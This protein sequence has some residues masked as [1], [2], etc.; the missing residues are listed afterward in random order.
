MKDNIFIKI[1][2]S[3]P[4][5]LITLYFLP[6]LGVILILLRLILSNNKRSNLFFILIV[7]LVL[8]IPKIISYLPFNL[9]NIPYLKQLINSEFYNIKIIKYSKFLITVSIIF[10][11]LNYLVNK[12][13]TNFTNHLKDKLVKYENNMEQQR[14]KAIKE[15]DM[16]IKERKEVAKNTSNIKCPYCGADNLIT[17][18]VGTCNYCRRKLE[19]LN[20][21]D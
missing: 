17:G 3:I 13:F 4:A 1:L 19:N 16:I 20:Y 9:D 8:L 12:F 2:I 15:N 10:I 6:F 18:K 11:I 7:G 21:K 14:I 5:I